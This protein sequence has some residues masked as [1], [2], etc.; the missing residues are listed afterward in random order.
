MELWQGTSIYFTLGLEHILDP[1]GFDHMLFILA[2]CAVFTLRQWR[3]VAVLV[4][5]FTIGHSLTLALAALDIFRLPADWVEFM[6]P[7]TILLTSL[8]NLWLLRGEKPEYRV[9]GNYLLALGFGLI[10]GMGFS[11][12]FRQLLMESESVVKPL[13]FFNL[14]IEAGQLLVVG[15]ILL[16]AGI[17][18]ELIRIPAKWW[19]MTLSIGT[20]L[21][22]L[23][24][25]LG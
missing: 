1:Q 8:Y 9:R 20:G 14:G 5:A 2:L 25:M 22:A 23:W 15:A 21:G 6:I 16:R 17:W 7:L 3:Q 13:L 18:V 10:H 11:N 4:T 12:F 24:L 19:T